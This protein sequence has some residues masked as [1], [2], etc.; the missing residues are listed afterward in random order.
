M[1][2]SSTVRML[3]LSL[4]LA[5]CG[6]GWQRV[7]H[8]SPTQLPV[9]QQVQ[10]WMGGES[11]VLHAVTLDP[12]SVSGVPFHLPPEC[13]SCRV[14]LARSTVDSIRLGSQERGVLRSMGAGYIAMVLAAL[15]LRLTIDID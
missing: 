7:D 8:L 4:L 13:D 15:A 6:A 1:P 2:R 3:V 12:R 14:V 10:L 9:R 5:A 11:R